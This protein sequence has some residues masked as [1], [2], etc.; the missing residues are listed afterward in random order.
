[1]P[2][3]ITAKLTKSEEMSLNAK[4]VEM[5]R[6]IDAYIGEINLLSRFIT[7]ADILKELAEIK[8]ILA[9]MTALLKEEGSEGR[10]EHLEYF[11]S[12][13]FPTVKKI[14]ESYNQ[15]ERQNFNVGSAVETKQRIAESIPFIRE[16]FEK[17]LDNM[18]KNKMLDITTDIDVLEAMLSKDGLLDKKLL[19]FK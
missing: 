10:F 5:V 6:K 13:Y 16:A 14:L 7:D 3:E 15:I 18:Y 2:P 19:K 17:E 12:Y 9:K 4:T 11:F 8:K 1:M